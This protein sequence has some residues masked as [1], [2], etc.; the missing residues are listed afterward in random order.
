[1]SAFLSDAEVEHLT[2]KV[3]WSAQVKALVAMRIAFERRPDG[4]PVVLRTAVQAGN[5]EKRSNG[6]NWNAA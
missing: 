1:M 5:E 3:R 6:P 4:K 2:G